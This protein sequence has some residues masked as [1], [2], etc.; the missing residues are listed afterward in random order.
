MHSVTLEWSI[1]AEIFCQKVLLSGTKMRYRNSLA[2][3]YGK[4][5]SLPLDLN[6]F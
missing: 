5:K 6:H 4:F 1:Q 3:K 2:I